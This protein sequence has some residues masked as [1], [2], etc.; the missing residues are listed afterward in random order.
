M[1]LSG[2]QK[3]EPPQQRRGFDWLG[4]LRILIIQVLVLVALS[5]AFIRYLNWSSEKE[6]AEFVSTSRTAAPEAKAYPRTEPP[7]QA[8]K[9]QAT[10]RPESLSERAGTCRGGRSGGR[11]G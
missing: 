1:T 9:A 6:W 11:D 4:T 10:P 8:V 7:L 3:E 2:N 5:G